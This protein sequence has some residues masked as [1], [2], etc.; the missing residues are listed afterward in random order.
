M[1]IEKP[2]DFYGVYAAFKRYQ[3]PALKGKHVKWYDR[4]FWVPAGCTAETSVLEIGSGTG[5]F[6]SYLKLKGVTRF[7]GVEQDPEAIRVMEPG[8][9]GN[10][11]VG[12]LWAYLE[13]DP[14]PFDRVVMLDVLEHFPAADGVRLL[15]KVKDVL[16]PGG[17][18]V[19]RVPNM[20]SPWGGIHQFADLTHQS[21]Y[22]AQ[23]LEQLGLAAGYKAR[24]FLPQRRGSPFRRLAEDCLHWVL[25]RIL[26]TTPVVWTAN[27][28]AVFEPE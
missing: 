11:T 25:S 1:A 24:A 16:R 18:V 15:N 28:I 7:H 19:V 3:T 21:A 22:S 10:V 20:G 6:L 8:L 12:D 9:E 17:L 23:S 5:E 14:E 2:E 13:G 26:S 4:E 27:I